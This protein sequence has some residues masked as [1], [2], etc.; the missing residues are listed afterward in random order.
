[1]RSENRVTSSAW[2]IRSWFEIPCPVPS[3]GPD[4]L[5]L[6][7]FTITMKRE[8]FEPPTGSKA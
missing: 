8:Y 4:P 6:K 2:A 7:W 1:M 5:D 3:S